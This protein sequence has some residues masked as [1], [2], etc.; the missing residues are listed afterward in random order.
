MS[1]LDDPTT[2]KDNNKYNN[3]YAIQLVAFLKNNSN[4]LNNY[5]V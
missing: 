1:N 5:F 4:N 2:K 3:D